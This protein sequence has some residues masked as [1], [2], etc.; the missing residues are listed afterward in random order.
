MIMP[1]ARQKLIG[2]LDYVEQV[3]RLDERVAFRLSEYRLPGT[4]LPWAST[5]RKI[6]PACVMT[7][8]M[9]RGRFG[10]KSNDLFAKS[11]QPRRKTLSNGPSCRPTR[12]DH[13]K[14]APNGW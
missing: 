6:F 8:A 11:P 3:V 2:L 14:F 5:T 9:K 12:R 1:D 4:I 13:P 10:S 7:I